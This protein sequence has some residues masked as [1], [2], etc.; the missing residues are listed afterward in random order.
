MADIPT[1]CLQ[2]ICFSMDRPWQVSEYLRT[3]HKFLGVELS[4][5][6]VLFKASN[7]AF[8][9]GYAHVMSLFPMVH[10]TEEDASLHSDAFK[11]GLLSVLDASTSEYVLFGV[12][13]AFFFDF[14]PV[15]DILTRPT[16]HAWNVLHL[17]LNPNIWYS[18]TQQM[19]LLPLPAMRWHGTEILT[20][21]P[22][23]GEWNYPW[24]VSGSI[25]RRD[26]VQAVLTTI[27]RIHGTHGLSQPNRLEANGHRVHSEFDWNEACVSKPIMH[28]LAINQVQ[29][30]YDNPLL[31]EEVVETEFLLSF[32]T[33]PPRRLDTARYKTQVFR[34][35]HVGTLFVENQEP[36]HG[37]P[38][39][40]KNA[41]PLISIV[42]PAYNESR[43]IH[44]ALDS[45][46]RQTYSRFEVLV[47]DDCS[48]DSTVAI[49][50]AFVKLDR[51]FRLVKN[52]M[53]MGVAKTLNRGIELATGDFIARMDGDDIALPDRLNMQ[54]AFLQTHPDV[55][56]VGSAI[57]LIGPDY[58]LAYEN[59][60]TA[61]ASPSDPLKVVVYP[62]TVARTR[63][64]LFMGCMLAHPTVFFR[65][66]VV[67]RFRYAE[68]LGS[69]ED[70]D[71]WLRL[72]VPPSDPP[73][74][75]V[76]KMMSLGTPLLL[77]RK[78]G[79]NAS[80]RKRDQQ[81]QEAHD[82][83]HAAIER[84]LQRPIESNVVKLVRSHALDQNN[85]EV[86]ALALQYAVPAIQLLHDIAMRC[87]ANES[88]DAME[89]SAIDS[90]VRA[91]HGE[92]AFRAM[93]IAPRTGVGLWQD[94]VTKCP[95][96]GRHI[97]KKL[98]RAPPTTTYVGP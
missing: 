96:E 12:D 14:F 1:T 83:A 22:G 15:M 59:G 70:Y 33:A 60:S 38:Y 89:K 58:T 39:E 10:W 45:L 32:L 35:V 76:V 18:E 75:P 71:L 93:M 95:A 7:A 61:D 49:V 40:S 8:R 51:R 84:L 92:L 25:Y 55:D 20:F 98:T 24:E 64:S 2:V 74:N 26:R 91:R 11:Q 72:A 6:W 79:R 88:C 68:S 73:A 78:H 97:F 85:N 57:A 36:S 23:R 65:R 21:E 37:A 27:E 5:V 52:P 44:Q 9:A 94:W 82:A 81:R 46:A 63:W 90:D 50:E 66:C 56:I 53:N 43:F 4:L 19:P 30:V 41:L 67:D 62:T 80:T 29:T 3:M 31:G 87:T 34:S 42:L 48:T 69:G 77:H 86:D 16:R 28:V 17:T 13:D 47:L 54:L